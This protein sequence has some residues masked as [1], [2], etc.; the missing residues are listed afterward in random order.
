METLKVFRGDEEETQDPQTFLRTFN[1][2]MRAV[3]VTTEADKIAVLQDYIA[4]RS[5]AQA[6]YDGL[7]ARQCT[8][9]AELE[10]SFNDKW[11]S[12]PMA[13]KTEETY[14]DELMALKL[15]ESEVGRTKEVNGIKVWTHVI[16]AKEAMRLA[17]AAKVEKDVG[18]VWIVHKKLPKVVRNLMKNKYKDFEEL[19]KEVKGL[20]V[21]EIKR[22]KEDVDEQRRDDEEQEK[23]LNQRQNA[24][25]ADL[26]AQLQRLAVQMATPPQITRTSA[27]PVR[28]NSVRFAIRQEWRANTPS[29]LTEAQKGVIRGNID[30]ITHHTTDTAGWQ[31]YQVQI[32]EWMRMHGETA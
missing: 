6:W 24:S 20:D 10:K 12:L 18:L 9:W 31:A 29:P 5:E 26:T 19:T 28:T 27:L 11:E 22:E 30:K 2:I 1:C 32:D 21:D 23:R 14:Q 25:I 4:P 16:W 3:G 17:R 8:T 7:T 15:E 13:E